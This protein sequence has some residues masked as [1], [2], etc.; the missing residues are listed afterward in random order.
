MIAEFSTKQID[1]NELRETMAAH[2]GLLSYISYNAMSA[3]SK[4]YRSI[5]W[6][7]Y[8][9][10]SLSA[11]FTLVMMREILN[12]DDSVC[13]S[14][15]NEISKIII[16]A[17]RLHENDTHYIHS[18]STTNL[19][20]KM[21][22]EHS[23]NQEIATNETNLYDDAKSCLS[24]V[25]EHYYG[26]LS[27]LNSS[28]TN[29]AIKHKALTTLENLMKEYKQF[30]SDESIKRLYDDLKTTS[31][32]VHYKQCN[33]KFWD[34]NK[35]TASYRRLEE[36]AEEKHSLPPAGVTTVRI[37]WTFNLFRTYTYEDNNKVHIETIPSQ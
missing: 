11:Y 18:N 28:A 37:S 15:K 7:N 17:L 33:Y 32:V 20:T 1:P 2:Y 35:P 23:R 25:D 4:F 14:E 12:H 13:L 8:S 26:Q 34:S 29:H 31:M 5:K 30:L 3:F 36:H 19:T 9:R 22:M 16:N 24:K 21:L 10:P 6:S 27:L